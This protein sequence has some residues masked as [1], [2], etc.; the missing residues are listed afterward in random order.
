[1]AGFFPKQFSGTVRLACTWLFDWLAVRSG[2]A[3][4]QLFSVFPFYTAQAFR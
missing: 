3:A 1:M 4:G 2:T